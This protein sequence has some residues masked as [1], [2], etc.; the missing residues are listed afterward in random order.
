MT[1]KK[2]QDVPKHRDR[3]IFG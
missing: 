1:K 3:K 2:Q